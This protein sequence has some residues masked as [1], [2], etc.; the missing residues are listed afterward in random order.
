MQSFRAETVIEKDGRLS[1]DHLPF[2]EGEAVHVFVS[3]A[4]PVAK[5]PLKES[6]LRIVTPAQFLSK[7]R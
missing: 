3:S 6:V 4:R 5:H 2:R 1:L 7:M